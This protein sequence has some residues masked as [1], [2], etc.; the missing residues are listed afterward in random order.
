L[1]LDAYF[2]DRL[3]I[4]VQEDLDRTL[5]SWDIEMNAEP[6]HLISND[7]PL[8]HQLALTV[9]F[10]PSRPT[11]AP[12]AGEVKG[13]AFFRVSEDLDD[14][15]TSQ[16]VILNGSAVLFGLLRAQVAQ[17]TGLGQFGPLL[18]PTINLVEAFSSQS[19]VGTTALQPADAKKPAAKKPAAKKKAPTVSRPSA[20]KKPT[21]P[22]KRTSG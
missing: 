4:E 5:A 3:T 20:T 1:Q 15:K 6:E 11:S 13:R 14:E 7:D 17:V 2:V 8:S 22:R 12:Y 16:Y 10:R 18:L 21:A 19:S 9:S